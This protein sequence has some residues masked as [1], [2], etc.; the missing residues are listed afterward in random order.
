[1][2]VTVSSLKK[3]NDSLK[4][5]IATLKQNINRL[6]KLL[7]QTDAPTASKGGHSTSS[8]LDL[9]TSTSLEFYGQS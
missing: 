3:E 6:Q 9:E 8:L 5:Q 4:D 7:R 2:P 1:M